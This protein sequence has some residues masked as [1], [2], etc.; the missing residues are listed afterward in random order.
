MKEKVSSTEGSLQKKKRSLRVASRFARHEP[1]QENRHCNLAAQAFLGKLR[2]LLQ[3]RPGHPQD[4][5]TERP[6]AAERRPRL[7]DTRLKVYF[8]KYFITSN[9]EGK[10]SKIGDERGISGGGREPCFRLRKRPELSPI[11]C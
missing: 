2:L 11:R 9:I 1:R 7:P 3:A 4:T 10:A 5:G 6:L 8:G